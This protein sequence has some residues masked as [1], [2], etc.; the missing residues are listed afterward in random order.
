MTQ[1]PFRQ[2][3]LDFHTS[4]HIPS[5]GERFD[6][7]AFGATLA[8]ADVDSVVLFAKCHHGWAYY[9]GEAA[10]RHPNLDFDLL[11][12]QVDSCRAAGVRTTIYLSVGWDEQAA[13]AQPGWRRVLPD[14]SFHMMLGRNL[15]P[16]WS[17][18]C[19]NTP[20]RERVLSQTRELAQLFRDSDGIWFDIIRQHEC[21]CVHCQDA[22]TKLGL[23]WTDAGHR[24]IH[25][26]QVLQD[27]LRDAKEAA[28]S[29]RGDWGVFHNTSLV[30]RG[31]R[32]FYDAFSHVEIEAVPTGGW[33]YDHFPMSARYLDPW[34]DEIMGVTVRF[35]LVWGE[36]GGFKHPDGLRAEIAIMQAHG[37]R[38]CVGDQL[39]PSCVLDPDAY[40]MVGRVYREARQ[41]EPLLHG[42]RSVAEIGLLSSIAI[43]E[44]GA[45]SRDAR[46]VAEDEGAFRI[47]QQSGFLFDVLDR[48][49][50]FA[51]YPA[52]VLP[53]R[54]RIDADLE[55]R[56]KRYL[57]GGGRIF[58]TGESLLRPD[59]S[60]AIDAGCVFEGPSRFSFIYVKSAAGLGPDYVR[61]PLLIYAP[62]LQVRATDG[63]SLG[64]VF[65]PWFDREP[66]R[67]NGH[68]T[69]PPKPEP[70]AYASGVVKNG[71]M[72][73]PQPV[74][75][76]F[77][78][79]GASAI[80]DYTAKALEH[81]LD[82]ER[83]LRT[84]LPSAGFATLRRAVSGHELLQ[85]VYAPRELRG[86]SLLGPIETI[87][88]APVIADI[89]ID[90]RRDQPVSRVVL[91]GADAEA[92]FTLREGRLRFTVP[93]M[94]GWEA[95]SIIP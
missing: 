75:S 12:A 78:Q 64:E 59:G 5:I 53:D 55:D 27:W 85:L 14:G 8:K 42:T 74:F 61:G 80:R 32:T 3:H 19:L 20:Y 7:G 63:Q 2:I 69:T 17:Y 39:D 62:T 73:L 77:R 92:R 48:D 95:V 40:A 4:E 84:N 11:R 65:E 83:M 28:Q 15:D 81:L 70:S 1:M 31:D 6:T 26:K 93:R 49:S 76:L 94:Q 58:A 33:G 45:V 67:F 30:P 38:I 86:Q 72:W 50:C 25:A 88:A 22:M 68:I 41:R 43:R 82:G 13:R 66:R 34:R 18:L 79:L 91:E 36:L 21:C 35:H 89:E 57:D 24:A 9:N 10:P 90:L 51:D 37:A 29:V 46:H 16:Y 87:D 44:P 47:L 54:I 52:L 71:V 23:D 56:L 60:I